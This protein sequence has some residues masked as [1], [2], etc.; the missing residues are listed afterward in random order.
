MTSPYFCFSYQRWSHSPASTNM[1]PLREE[2]TKKVVSEMVVMQ[3][4]RSLQRP[5]ILN[6]T[7]FC[8]PNTLLPSLFMV[9]INL[10]MI[11]IMLN[12]A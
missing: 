12:L 11:L 3:S 4:L 7:F 5:S 2:S 8:Y 9:L 1:K 10:I 6:M